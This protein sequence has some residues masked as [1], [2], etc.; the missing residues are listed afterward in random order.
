MPGY[1]IYLDTLILKLLANFFFEFILLWA[2]A[3]VTKTST[4]PSRIAL[5][6]SIGTFHYLLFLLAGY[7]LIPYYGLLKFFPILIAVSILMIFATF[8]P[9]SKGK[10]LLQTAAYFYGI[11]F[12]SAGAGLA[13]GY[14][15]GSPA[16]PQSTVGVLVSI[17]TILIIAELGWGIVQK[18]IYRNVYQ[19]SVRIIL[20]QNSVDVTALIDT[21]NKLKDP[22]TKQPVIVVEQNA[23]LPLFDQTTA[24]L[25]QELN[26]GNMNVLSD[27]TDENFAVRFRV[28][29][30]S[31]IGKEKGMLV[32][33]RPDLIEIID[34]KEKYQLDRAIIAVYQHKLDKE[35]SYQALIP[36]EL[37]DKYNNA[38]H[39]YLH[40]SIERGEQK[41]ATTSQPQR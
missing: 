26:L 13:A 17:S 19:L 21:G 28:I 7:R 29:P 11:G 5:G 27:N 37:L 3:Q 10:K 18:R 22:L 35:G 8:Y 20:D 6:A 4:K 40:K 25:F 31:T 9:N 15:F 14:L 33:F 24:M 30:F 36:P 39:S 16:N 2:T 23:L 34:N 38:N 41:H 1:V 32:G 12:I